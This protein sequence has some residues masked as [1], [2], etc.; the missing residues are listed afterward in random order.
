MEM[1][2][3]SNKAYVELNNLFLNIERGYIKLTIHTMNQLRLLLEK[4][5]NPGDVMIGYWEQEFQK[6]PDWNKI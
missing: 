4:A 2:A 3:E 5:Y 1:T 6:L